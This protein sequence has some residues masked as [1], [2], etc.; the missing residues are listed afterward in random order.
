M[1]KIEQFQITSMS[2]S[3][4]KSYEKP[5]ELTFGNPTV[6]TGGNGRGKTSIA[7]AIAFA[8][9]GL[10][11]FGERG[12]DRLHNEKNPDVAIQMRFVDENG[13]THELTRIRR[14][15]DMSIYYDGHTIRQL[16]LADL[17]GERD[18]FLSILNPLYFI[19]ELGTNGKNLLERYLP[20]IPQ[21]TILAQLPGEVQASL[22]DEVILSPDAYLKGRRAEIRELDERIT[23]LSGQKDLA[24]TQKKQHE[25]MWVEISE[26]ITALQNEIAA[27]AEKQFADLDTAKMQEQLVELS[28]RYDEMARDERGDTVQQQKELRALR[29]KIVRRQSEQYQSKFTEPLAEIAA[30][31]N[32]LGTRYKR[33]SVAYKA[34]HAGMDCPTC[35]RRVTEETLPEVQA[36]LKKNISELYAAGTEQKGQL[37]ELQEMDKKARDT[38]DA[39]KEADLRKW[40]EDAAELER[41]CAE[42]SETSS[43]AAESLRS[44]IQALTAE[45]EYGNLT[46]AEYGRL[47]ECREQCRELESKLSALNEMASAQTPDFD[48]EIREAQE[49][50]GKIKRTMTNVIS[51]VSKRAELTFSQLKMNRVEISLYDVVKST[52]EVKDTFKFQYGGRRYDRLS[53]SEKIRAGM[54]LSELIKRLTGRNYPVFVD[55]MESVDDLANVRPTGQIIMAKCV[56]NAP[57]QVR[58]IKP[59]VFAEQRAA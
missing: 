42:Q 11:L 59:I 38:F 3:G 9:T 15:N 34:F 8:V 40:T 23:Y 51:Y 4:F 19:E 22:K 50:I 16:D 53:L 6:I 32:D 45:L 1:K 28:Q 21:E 17:F 20:F 25:T 36:A 43:Q 27:L 39:F 35:H 2:I 18:V 44:E 48:R 12:L 56:S 49:A 29:E 31:V 14:N 24:A 33:E 46:Q 7:D 41:R 47:R 37:T 30:K 5:T 54:E 26:G 57:L 13:I 58:P 52:G 55:N 10:P